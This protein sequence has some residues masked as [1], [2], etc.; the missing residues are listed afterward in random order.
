MRKV[1]AVAKDSQRPSDREDAVGHAGAGA[2]VE[3]VFSSHSSSCRPGCAWIVEPEGPFI[4]VFT[5][6][7]LASALVA[8]CRERIRGIALMACAVTLAIF[9]YV[10]AGRDKLLVASILP[11]P[12]LV[13]GALF[14]AAWWR[15]RV[16]GAG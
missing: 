14:L 2:A 5:A 13:S 10:T 9:V 11:S 1:A 3:P 4:A 15:T 8:W 12:F 6:V 7:V 16:I